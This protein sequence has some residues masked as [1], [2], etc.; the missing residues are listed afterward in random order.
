MDYKKMIPQGSYL[1][2]F[3]VKDSSSFE[4]W[5]GGERFIFPFKDEKTFER[6]KLILS[7]E[8]EVIAEG[9]TFSGAEELIK[10]VSDD[11][12]EKY[13]TETKKDLK[14]LQYIR[15]MRKWGLITDSEF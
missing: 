12:K 9:V 8:L 1:V 6:R 3:E 7:K 15:R 11:M 4:S 10:E 14:L 5:E 13:G 2:V